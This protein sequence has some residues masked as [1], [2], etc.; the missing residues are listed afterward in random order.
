MLK[1][2]DGVAMR[3]P[4]ESALADIFVGFCESNLFKNMRKA[5]LYYRYVD[6]IFVAF[7]SEKDCEEL[8]NHLISL[9][10]SLRFTFEKECDNC[11]SF[12]DVLVEKHD[13]EFVTSVHRKPT[14]T[15]HYL[16]WN[17]FN[18]RKRKISLV[19]I[20]GY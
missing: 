10:S 19:D 18:T 1:Q 8:V 4:L 20:L 6:N 5:L 16:R 13:T 12:L 15:G 3:S 2:I 14:F 11:L 17:S 7:N 9:H